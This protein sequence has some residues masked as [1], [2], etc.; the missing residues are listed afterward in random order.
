MFERST[1]VM[2]FHGNLRHSE[3]HYDRLKMSL[4]QGWLK[5]LLASIEVP[6]EI[7]FQGEDIVSL[8]VA[9]PDVLKELATNPLIRVNPGFF[10]HALS[11]SYPG[12]RAKQIETSLR[13]AREYL[14]EDKLSWIHVWPEMDISSQGVATFSSVVERGNGLL[15]LKD[16]RYTYEYRDELI[17]TRK[18]LTD[19]I[20]QCQGVPIIAAEAADMRNIYLGFYRNVFSPEDF[21]QEA[22]KR[23]QA[24]KH[25]FVV[26]FTDL[27]APLINHLDDNPQLAKW[28][29]FQRALKRA[30]DTGMIDFVSFNDVKDKLAGLIDSSPETVI[31]ERDDMKW[32][33]R[34]PEQAEA[35]R[36]IYEQ[37]SLG[38]KGARDP[39]E[40][41]MMTVSDTF[42]AHTV[43]RMELDVLSQSGKEEVINKVIIEPDTTARMNELDWLVGGM[44][45]LTLDNSAINWHK[46]IL[47]KVLNRTREITTMSRS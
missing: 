42:S 27:E 25:N 26:F 6:T 33:G 20:M 29:A 47:R 24:S 5:E 40:A 19:T 35:L 9:A 28:R 2:V 46:Q 12:L 32:Y 44:Q 37:I 18:P 38:L 34:T 7:S 1:V 41:M 43:R 22:L 16:L 15:A 17:E 39:I 10:T 36:E 23:T 3:H 13:V 14:P 30:N 8:E 21:I 11:S 31:R 4:E 45:N